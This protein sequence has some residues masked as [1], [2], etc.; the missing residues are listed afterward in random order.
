MPSQINHRGPSII[1]FQNINEPTKIAAINTSLLNNYEEYASIS[2]S[3]F[4]NYSLLFDKNKQRITS[5]YA[6]NH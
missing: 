4:A 2:S 5:G 1:K 3:I 6:C